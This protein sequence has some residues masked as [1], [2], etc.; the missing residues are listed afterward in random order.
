MNQLGQVE[1]HGPRVPFLVCLC[2]GVATEEVVLA[3]CGWWKEGG[4][5]QST[6][7]MVNLCSVD[8]LTSLPCL[9]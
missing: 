9:L 7:S 8:L 2:G 5:S 4:D 1:L 3:E 6:A